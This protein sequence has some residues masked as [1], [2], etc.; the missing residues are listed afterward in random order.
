[1]NIK[2]PLES[3]LIGVGDNTLALEN[4]SVYADVTY[5]VYG[6]ETRIYDF[7]PIAHNGEIELNI[8]E[9]TKLVYDNLENYQDPFDYTGTQL[10]TET[11]GY[12][13]IKIHISAT[14]ADN[15]IVEVLGLSVVNAA[16]D[17]GECLILPSLEDEI[18][19]ENAGKGDS[20]TTVALAYGLNFYLH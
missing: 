14:D 20:Q 19:D 15:S 16:L 12:H 6:T 11:D 18:L 17:V 8:R 7:C 3:S 1:M 2:Q 4:V 5:T 9:I 10:Y 13:Y